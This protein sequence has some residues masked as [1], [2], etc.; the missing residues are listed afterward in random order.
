MG[1]KEG[2]VDVTKFRR[3]LEE[4]LSCEKG[5]SWKH[6]ETLPTADLAWKWLE[7]KNLLVELEKDLL[8]LRRAATDT[9]N[10][11]FMLIILV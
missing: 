6:D 7:P 3:W 10:R 11:P 1:M 9:K 2:R 4:T 8:V 5:D